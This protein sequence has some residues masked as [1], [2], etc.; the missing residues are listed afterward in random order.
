MRELPQRYTHSARVGG[1]FHH[2]CFRK[3]SS[4]RCVAGGALWVAAAAAFLERQLPIGGVQPL[5]APA[6][7]A[8]AHELLTFGVGQSAQHLPPWV[9]KAVG[10]ALWAPGFVEAR[11]CHYAMH[12]A[13]S[14]SMRASSR[15]P[16]PSCCHQR[17]SATC[18]AAS[19]MP[20]VQLPSFVCWTAAPP[21][22]RPWPP[23]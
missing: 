7:S 8:L 15:L 20:T 21:Q 14:S 5:A 4:G 17:L 6:F 1:R 11:R 19:H 9:P 10:A 12:W 16:L 22:D 18:H 23:A 3:E 2:Q 13:P